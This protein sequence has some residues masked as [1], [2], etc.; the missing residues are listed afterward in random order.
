MAGTP[1]AGRRPIVTS[2]GPQTTTSAAG[3]TAVPAGLVAF[4]VAPS[5]QLPI[6]FVIAV[7]GDGS[8]RVSGGGPKVDVID[9]PGDDGITVF[10]G[11]DPLR[12]SIPIV[13][14]G[15]LR[16]ADVRGEIVKLQAFTAP[17]SGEPPLI[18]VVGAV[19]YTDLE[20]WLDGGLDWGDSTWGTS[21]TLL[22]QAMTVNLVEHIADQ[23]LTTSISRAKANGGFLTG[24]RTVTPLE[25]ESVWDLV[26][27]IYGRHDGKRIAAIAKAN[28]VRARQKLDGKPLKLGED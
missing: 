8:A 22:R 4:K 19:P 6:N 16:R 23:K 2:S 12:L 18:T 1:K 17:I 5:R 3:P 11:R 25:G 9:R 10:R 20:W 15:F 24:A 7:L 14:D 21:G 28:N 26:K 13:F 27:R